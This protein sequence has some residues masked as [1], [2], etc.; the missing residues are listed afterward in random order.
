MK[1]KLQKNKETIKE[2]KVLKEG[3]VDGTRHFTVEWED[4][5]QE[6]T[7][8]LPSTKYKYIFE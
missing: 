5:T 7:A 6:I 2:G 8:A 3:Y 4:G 1:I